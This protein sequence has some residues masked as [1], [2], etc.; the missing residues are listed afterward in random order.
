MLLGLFLRRFWLRVSCLLVVS[1]WIPVVLFA[2]SILNF[3]F[4]LIN[5]NGVNVG[6]FC[7]RRG[8]FVVFGFVRSGHYLTV[9][10][11]WLCYVGW[12]CFSRF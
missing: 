11:G 10:F 3:G 2:E 4:I 7:C 9:R 6:L 8:S 1:R 12:G 5:I